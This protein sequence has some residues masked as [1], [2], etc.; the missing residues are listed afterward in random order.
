MGAVEPAVTGHA[1][2]GHPAV[3]PRPD[4]EFPG[5]VLRHQRAVEGGQA[6]VAHRDQ[7]PLGDAG[8]PSLGVLDQEPAG[9]DPASEVEFLHVVGDGAGGE[10]QPGAVPDPEGEGLPVRQVDDALVLDPVAVDLVGS[11]AVLAAAAA[12]ASWWMCEAGSAWVAMVSNSIG[13][14]QGVSSF[15]FS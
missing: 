7:P 9:E 1:V 12:G 11:N 10:V 15:S 13:L 5:P 6:R 14:L 2:V 8:P 4:G 3:Q